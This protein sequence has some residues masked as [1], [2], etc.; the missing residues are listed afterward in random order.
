MAVGVKRRALGAAGHV[1]RH[2]PLDQVQLFGFIASSGVR[3][4]P[5]ALYRRLHQRGPIRQG[6]YG[7]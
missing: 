5:W 1:A 3:A 2:V 6:P 7:I 4:D